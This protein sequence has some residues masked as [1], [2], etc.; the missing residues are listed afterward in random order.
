MELK[1]DI[2][3]VSEYISRYKYVALIVILGVLMMLIPFGETK[4]DTGASIET[5]KEESESFQD[6]LCNILSCVSGA[7]RVE[8]MLSLLEGEEIVY[9]TDDNSTI[10][11]NSEANNKKIVTVTD[12]QRNQQ[13]LI[14]QVIPATYKGAIIICQGAD[15]PAVRLNLINAVSKLTG[16][17][18]DKISVLKMK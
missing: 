13:G 17:G 4:E 16:L 12:A 7:G 15:D 9:Q 5:P 6:Q 8:V 2:K 14:K 18:A 11:N 3:R 1:R 10:G